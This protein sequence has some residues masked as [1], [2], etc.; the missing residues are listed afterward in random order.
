MRSDCPS[1][2]ATD[3]EAFYEVL[4]VPT[5]SCILIGSR[6]EAL[7]FPTA[8]LRLCLC[9]HCGFIF[10]G[11]WQPGRTIYR[12][13]YE[14]TQAYSPTFCAFD[15]RLAESLVERHSVRSRDILEIGCGK[16][17]F[18]A[19][20]C[21]IGGNRGVGYDPGHDPGR[22]DAATS[23]RMRV[24]RELFTDRT[25]CGPADLVCCKMTLEHIFD[26]ADFVGAVVRNL[27]AGRNPVVFFQVPDADR[28]L[29]QGAFWDIYY[30]HVSYFTPGSLSRLFQRAGFAVERTWTDYGG[31]YLMIEG[32]HPVSRSPEPALSAD[33][34]DRVAMQDRVGRF[35]SLVHRAVADWADRIRASSRS[36]KKVVLWG[37]GS[38]AVSF[39]TTVGLTLA[40]IEYVVDVNPHRHGMYLPRSGQQIVSPD[41]LVDYRPD[42][43][44]VMNPIYCAEIAA[45]LAVRGCS[46]E[47]VT[48]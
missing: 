18:L 12:E 1:C 15:R 2:R 42:M 6:E 45:C 8:D 41:F 20:L 11:A 16:G 23:S 30:E 34:A 10:N 28:I 44:I 31:Q 24:V 21:E 35:S 36:G 48:V 22:L 17:E 3:L 46:P 25:I 43:V 14:E 26:V 27:D 7:D 40:D 9:R 19:L 32:R 5:N 4:D 33:S 13:G 29:D 39:L 37:S 38:K 47:L